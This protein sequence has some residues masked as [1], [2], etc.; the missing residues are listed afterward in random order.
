MKTSGLGSL[1]C[2]ALHAVTASYATPPEASVASL[3]E[4]PGERSCSSCTKE[5][6]L[7]HKYLGQYEKHTFLIQETLRRPW[8]EGESVLPDT[9]EALFSVFIFLSYAYT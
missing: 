5:A 6:V 2:K 3:T 4:R 8:Q 1:V 7:R 9:L